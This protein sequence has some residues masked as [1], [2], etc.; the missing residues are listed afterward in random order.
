MLMTFGTEIFDGLALGSR[1]AYLALSHR[2]R[3]VPFFGALLYGIMTPIGIA[4]GIGMRIIYDPSTM[5]TSL[6]SGVLESLSAGILMYSGFVEL[7]AKGFLF[8][9]EMCEAGI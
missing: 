5:H 8:K 9:P 2:Y 7:P 1:L 4:M 3:Y 6:F